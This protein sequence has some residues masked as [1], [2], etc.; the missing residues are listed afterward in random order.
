MRSGITFLEIDNTNKIII[1]EKMRLW[2][3]KSAPPFFGSSVKPATAE[4]VVSPAQKPGSKKCRRFSF[5]RRS[6]R[7]IRNVAK[8][9]PIK[10]AANVALRLSLTDWPSPYRTSVPATP[11]RETKTRDF[12]V[13]KLSL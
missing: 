6:M 1:I 9:T 12:R 10:F 2:R 7:T 4:N 5:P 3:R 8:A 13:A 11:P